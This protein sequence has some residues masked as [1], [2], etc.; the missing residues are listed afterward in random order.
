MARRKRSERLPKAPIA[1]TPKVGVPVLPRET[2]GS[3]QAFCPT[4][5]RTIAER[6]A[7]VR[8]KLGALE[9]TPYFDSIAW[10]P[11]KP[12][13]V[14]LSTN[15]KGSFRDWAYISKEDAPELF[16]ALK[17]RLL[18]A[19]KEWLQKGWITEDEIARIIE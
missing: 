6:R 5:G 3:I 1:E 7:T 18:T 2:R 10:D 19:C 8:S 15:G 16:E 14:R 13:G 4:C 17:N 11:D 9:T 12:F